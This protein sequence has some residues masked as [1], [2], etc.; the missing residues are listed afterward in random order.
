MKRIKMIIE[1]ELG[2]MCNP[3]D[4]LRETMQDID[5]MDNQKVVGGLITVETKTLAQ[6]R[7]DNKE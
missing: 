6:E 2:D 7:V 4:L 3:D 5:C 1:V